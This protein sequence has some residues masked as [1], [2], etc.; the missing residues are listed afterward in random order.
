V[1]HDQ[2]RDMIGVFL[3]RQ[4]PKAYKLGYPRRPKFLAG[5]LSL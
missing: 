5:E 3:M 2:L 4:M 1:G